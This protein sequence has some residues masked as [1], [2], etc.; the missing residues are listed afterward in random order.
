[1]IIFD[2]ITKTTLTLMLLGFALWFG[3]SI[4]RTAIGYD[5]FSPEAVLS[6]KSHY[7][8]Q[9][10]MQN[11]YLFANLAIYTAIGYSVFFISML[12]L[13]FKN[14]SRLKQNGWLLMAF[15]LLLIASPVQFY[16]MYFDYNLAM[17]VVRE[18]LADFQS[19]PVQNYF[20]NRFT[21]DNLT[22]LSSLSFLITMTSAIYFI[23]M[24]L[25]KTIKANEN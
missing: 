9:V 4:L 11:V 17:P 15:V 6:L 12:V 18:R 20:L 2:K 13:F 8:P 7:S 16:L 5:L 23:W 10:Q 25:K 22:V 1:M 3:G 24:P 19:Y 14:K 21:N